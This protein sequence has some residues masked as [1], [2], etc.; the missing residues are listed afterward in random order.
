[1]SLTVHKCGLSKLKLV[2]PDNVT[3]DLFAVISRPGTIKHDFEVSSEGPSSGISKGQS[4]KCRDLVFR[5]GSE[6]T[7]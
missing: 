3:G 7:L 4:S 1:M 6:T 5:L 2:S